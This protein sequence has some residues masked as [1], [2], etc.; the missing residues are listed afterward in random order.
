MTYLLPVINLEETI[1]SIVSSIHKKLVSVKSKGMVVGVSGGVD[2]SVTLALS[3][4]VAKRYGYTVKAYTLPSNL[5]STRTKEFALD[6]SEK[7]DTEVELIDIEKAVQGFENVCAHAFLSKYH[8]GNMASRIRGVILNTKA[9]VNNCIVM[10]TGNY[11]EDFCI[12]YY[13]LFGD[14][15]VHYSPIGLLPKRIVRQLA[16]YFGLHDIADQPPTAELEPGQTDFLDL[17]YSYDAV[18]AIIHL[19]KKIDCNQDEVLELISNHPRIKALITPEILNRGNKFKCITEVAAD[20][21]RR[22]CT[23]ALP[24]MELIHPENA[25]ARLCHRDTALMIGRFQPFHNG[26]VNMFTSLYCLGIKKLVIVI[27]RDVKND[28][29]RNPIEP[30][31]IGNVIQSFIKRCSDTPFQGMKF[32]VKIIDDINRPNEYA[33][34]IS[35][36]TGLNADNSLIASNNPYVLD[37]FKKWPQFTMGSEKNFRISATKIR[38]MI[39]SGD[40][41]WKELVPKET[42]S[43]YSKG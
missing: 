10:G 30:M 19:Y 36:K 13:T 38:E 16:R 35:E 42:V 26:H 21:I 41:S 32:D 12:G 33:G 6:L 1:D 31:L 18:E 25:Q 34:Y 24:K 11:D 29:L 39:K 43:M 15:A 4:V 7:F 9:A 23:S 14:G 20:I 8:K 2:S 5:N 22:H 17:G 3:C 37:C 40:T 28:K 27:G